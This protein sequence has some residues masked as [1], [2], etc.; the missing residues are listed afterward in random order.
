M[1]VGNTTR[2]QKEHKNKIYYYHYTILHYTLL[3]NG[4][5]FISNSFFWSFNSKIGENQSKIKNKSYNNFCKK[6]KIRFH[7]SDKAGERNRYKQKTVETR[8]KE[9]NK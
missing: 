8:G 3:L 1:G 5:L 7:R 4:D 6:L 9:I 2:T